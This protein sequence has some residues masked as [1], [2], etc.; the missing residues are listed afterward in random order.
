MATK[1]NR[2]APVAEPGHMSARSSPIVGIHSE[3]RTGH[4]V[5]SP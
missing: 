1:L 3:C 2:N 4:A 5:P